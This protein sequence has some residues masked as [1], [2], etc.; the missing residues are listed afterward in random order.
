MNPIFNTFLLNDCIPL[1]TM[2]KRIFSIRGIWGYYYFG[3]IFVLALKKKKCSI[4]NYCTVPY[5]IFTIFS[6]FFYLQQCHEF[7]LNVPTF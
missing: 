3:L 2:N 4:F 1:Y 5:G 6:L 7:F